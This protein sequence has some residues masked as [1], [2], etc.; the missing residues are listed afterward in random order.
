[1]VIVTGSAG[2]IGFHLSFKLLEKGYEVIGIDNMNN[3]Y[4]P[5]LKKDRNSL[6]SKFPN[7]HFYLLDLKD[8]DSTIALFKKFN[9]DYVIHLA[10]Q[11][12]VRYSFEN[13]DAYIE[14]NIIVFHNILE[15]CKICPPKH[16]L[17][18]SSS[19][20]YG[21]TYK[22]PFSI[23]DCADKPLSIYA[24]TK[25]SNELFAYVYSK[26]YGIPTTGLRFFTVYGPW[27]RPDMS[28]FK[29]TKLILEDKEI[30]LYKNGCVKR[31]FTYI[32]DIIQSLII[33]LETPPFF[34][35]EDEKYRI[36]NIGNKNPVDIE[37]IVE[38]LE[39][40]IGKRAKKIYKPLPKGDALVTCAETIE[41]ER[42][43][44]FKPN[45]PLEKGLENFY[46]W[47]KQ[48]YGIEV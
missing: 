6:L 44:N 38:I 24:A 11:A 27:G 15:A 12:G 28:Y 7:Y 33:I 30:E 20:V 29:F 37:K 21:N 31:D 9:P 8:K 32:D 25:R 4:D 35:K 34:E 17:F 47:Y 18:A 46:K 41:L 14:S 36:Y 39:N 40:I 10:A 13:T 26:T 45:T 16:L 3:Y 22:L 42:D 43:Y 2:F 1:M 5:K 19:S 48:Y 23:Q